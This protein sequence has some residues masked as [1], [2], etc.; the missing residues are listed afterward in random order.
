MPH[1]GNI[2][3][4]CLMI[5]TVENPVVV[6]KYFAMNSAP[7]GV[8]RPNVGKRLKYFDPVNNSRTAAYPA[9]A[10]PGAEVTEHP[11]SIVD[12]VPRSIFSDPFLLSTSH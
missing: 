1:P 3:H 2:D 11:H 6:A 10:K 4:T 7:R 9:R 8:A 5:D 12:S